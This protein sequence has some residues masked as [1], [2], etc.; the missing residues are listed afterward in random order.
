MV[1][2][3]MRNSVV[4]V[5]HKRGNPESKQAVSLLYKLKFYETVVHTTDSYKISNILV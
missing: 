4:T 5:D 3:L 1:P 2:I